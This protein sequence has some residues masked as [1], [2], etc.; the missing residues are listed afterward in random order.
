MCE[1]L[2][3]W[4]SCFVCCQGDLNAANETLHLNHPITT[5]YC[6]HVSQEEGRSFFSYS[7]GR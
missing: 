3:M 2:I 4:D 5:E 1:K 7:T 6:Y